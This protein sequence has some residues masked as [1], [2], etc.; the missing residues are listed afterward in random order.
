MSEECPE[1][2]IWVDG[3]L[4][5]GGVAC[6]PVLDRGFL[7]G[8]GCFEGMRVRRKLL[9][10]PQDHL[11]RLRR[12][13]Q[14]LGIRCAYQPEQIMSAIAE[15]MA[16]NDLSDAHVRVILTR[17]SSAPAGL[18]PRPAIRPRLVVLAY[19][20]PVPE[21]PV[22]LMVSSI[23]RKAPRSV[24]AHIK[25]LNYLD[26]ILAKQQAIAAGAD[27]A[28]MLDEAGTV[29]E[30]TLTNVFVVADG[31][32]AT[33]TTRAALPGI[34]RRTVIEILRDR[35]IEVAE[36]DVTWGEMYAADECFLTGSATGI[37]PV[38]AVDGRELTGPPGRI[39][40]LVRTEYARAVSKPELVVDL[41]GL[42]ESKA[43]YAPS[44]TS[45]GGSGPSGSPAELCG[46]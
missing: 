11:T 45:P 24:D 33:P 32:V 8:D 7:Y 15:V 2:S 22:R 27:D 44:G 16:S 1:L 20:L 13:A 12:S 43:I 30:A 35:E 14:A 18:D 23:A 10:R 36:R 37:L 28:L 46:D 6:I 9:F 38:A 25:S 40:S 29:A 41:A 42:A 26:G 21:R 19:P 17:G 39:T 5:P 4:I 3:R 31:A 34:T